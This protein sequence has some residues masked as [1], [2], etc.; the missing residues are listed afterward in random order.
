MTSTRLLDDA[1]HIGPDLI[2]L[3]RTIHRYPELSFE[4]ERTSALVARELSGL[5]LEVQAGFGAS[6]AVVASLQGSLP[7]SQDAPRH[8]LLRADMDALNIQEESGE[9]FAS[10]RPG[11]M[12][13]CGHDA[14][15]A[16]LVGAARLLAARRGE[17]SGRISFVFQP[18]EENGRGARFLIEKGLLDE[19][20]ATAAFALHSDPSLAAGSVSIREGPVFASGAGFS[21]DIIGRGG[22]PGLPHQTVDAIVVAA[23]VIQALQLLASREADP[24]KPFTLGIGTI[25]GGTRANVIA[26]RVTLT[27]TLRALD[28]AVVD[29]AL[30]RLERI[31][32]GTAEALGA[33]CS[34]STQGGGIPLVNDEGM[35]RLAR[36]ALVEVL[37]A[38]R[39]VRGSPI[40]AGEDFALIAQR[41]PAAMMM[42]GVGAP[43]AESFPLHHP[44]FAID[45]TALPVGAAAL[46]SCTL[47]YLAPASS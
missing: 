45:E 2:A 14:H 19:P 11:F 26:G 23:Q 34:V 42:L 41:V 4:E 22:H 39:V 9:D 12:H 37:G 33:R 27:G 38:D 13:A 47:A 44:R 3:R 28:A 36:E 10:E 16:I 24:Q 15:T 29:H 40:L 17:F 35:A 43:G 31:A 30:S 18:G 32:V 46:A 7:G 8:L 6:T 20:R 1:R 25:Q 21:I 5:G